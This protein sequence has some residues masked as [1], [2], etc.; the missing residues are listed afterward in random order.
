MRLKKNNNII[1]FDTETV[2][3]D[4][5]HY[6]SLMGF[7]DFRKLVILK[8]NI[9]AKFLYLVYKSRC[10]AV[11]AHNF[12]SFDSYFIAK[13]LIMLKFKIKKIYLRNNCIYFLEAEI[14]G[15]KIY[16]RDS[17]LLFPQKLTKIIFS[18]TG[19]KKRYIATERV[20]TKF[21]LY[22]IFDVFFLY[23]IL[24]SSTFLSKVY[25]VNILQCVSST[26]FI[27][28]IFLKT[29]K[30]KFV[31]LLKYIKNYY[32]QAAYSGGF[33]D[34]MDS[35][36]KNVYYYDINSLYPYT[37]LKAIPWE[38]CEWVEGD[39]DL[40]N[41]FGFLGVTFTEKPY[42][43]PNLNKRFKKTCI[44]FSE[45][46]KFAE[47]LGYKYIIL[48][49]LKFNVGKSIFNNVV[50][51]FYLLKKDKDT[52]LSTI[53]KSLLNS[54]Y[55]RFALKLKIENSNYVSAAVSSYARIEIF[56]YKML[57]HY[58]YSDTDSIFVFNELDKKYIGDKI[59]LLKLKE[60][61]KHMYI[62]K[63]KTYYYKVKRG[64]KYKASGLYKHLIKDKVKFN[65]LAI[66]IK[67]RKNFNLTLWETSYTA[68][69]NVIK[70]KYLP[71]VMVDFFDFWF[72]L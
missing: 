62:L 13:A 72:F 10:N 24:K 69:S 15:K 26:Q 34:I 71:K 29:L 28:N 20:S 43:M 35:Y 55:G 19:F 33:V 51:H 41:F 42:N 63:E 54:L 53:S 50:N 22:L 44:L 49:Y 7:L 47:K 58:I 67:R 27:Y 61:T 16:F 65:K 11:Y 40:D 70:K 5:V 46:L 31:L 12:S 23:Y 1:V 48:N 32:V 6:I 2:V 57:Q 9:I 68:S 21:L 8:K 30:V 64:Y 18:L 60:F 37:M 3:L 4:N 25:K 45:E 66:S 14:E 59:G 39:F 56:Q 38:F 52:Y 36:G 17:Y